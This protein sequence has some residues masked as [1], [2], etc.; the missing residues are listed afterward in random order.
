M[1][2]SYVCTNC[3]NI[4]EFRPNKVGH[5]KQYH[6][7][8]VCGTRNGLK[9]H[10]IFNTQGIFKCGGKNALSRWEEIYHREVSR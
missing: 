9:F 4:E 2:K 10:P 3:T 6:D 8:K 1:K 7:C 5:Y